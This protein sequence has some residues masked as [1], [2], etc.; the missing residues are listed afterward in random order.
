MGKASPS[1]YETCDLDKFKY[2]TNKISLTKS[3]KNLLDKIG[4]LDSPSPCSF[5]VMDAHIKT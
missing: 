1:H 3:K 5:D 4:K 2:R